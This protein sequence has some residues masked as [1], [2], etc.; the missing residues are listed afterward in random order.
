MI[1]YSAEVSRLTDAARAARAALSAALANGDI[2][3]IKE[4]RAASR[5]AADALFN[6]RDAEWRA[7]LEAGKP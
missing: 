2:A 5:L 1:T 6:R 7:Y 4:A 3:A